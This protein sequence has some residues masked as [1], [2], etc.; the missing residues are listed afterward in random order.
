MDKTAKRIGIAVVAILIVAL[1]CV[2]IL[3]AP[4]QAETPNVSVEGNSG[5]LNTSVKAVTVNSTTYDLNDPTDANEYY[6]ML[7]KQGYEPIRDN[8]ELKNFVNNS[9]GDVDAKAAVK[10]YNG[11]ERITY[12]LGECLETK[13]SYAH[14]RNTF[15]AT[16]DGCGAA[17]DLYIARLTGSTNT[18]GGV[19]VRGDGIIED[20]IAGGAMFAEFDQIWFYGALA[21]IAYGAVVK[22]SNF[23]IS[24][25]YVYAAGS[26]SST[27]DDMEAIDWD[28]SII[29]GGLFGGMTDTTIDNCSLEVNGKVA[30]SKTSDEKSIQDGLIGFGGFAGYSY[31]STISNTSLAINK[32]I[33][34]RASGTNPSPGIYYGSPHAY[35]GG[36]VALSQGLSA[37]N[38]NITGNGAV[39]SSLGVGKKKES[40]GIARA[41]AIIGYDISNGNSALAKSEI[42]L[43]YFGSSTTAI[44]GVLTQYTG[45]TTQQSASGTGAGSTANSQS[46]L[47]GSIAAGAMANVFFASNDLNSSIKDTAK[48]AY[49]TSIK[50]SKLF[51]TSDDYGTVTIEFPN[52]TAADPNTLGGP[53]VTYSADDEAH[54]LWSY[55][56]GGS[57]TN[58]YDKQPYS[59]YSIDVT[60]NSGNDLLYS[61]TSGTRVN[62]TVRHNGDT[63]SDD[64][65]GLDATV[66]DSKQF[67]NTAFAYPELVLTAYGT[68]TSLESMSDNVINSI[69]GVYSGFN[70]S[71]R[72]EAVNVGIY[73]YRLTSNYNSGLTYDFVDTEKRYVAYKSD[74]SD[75][76]NIVR[77]YRFEITPREIT[78]TINQPD[79]VYD[80]TIKSLDID[81]K[82][83]VQGYTT[84]T[85]NVSYLNGNSEFISADEIVD[86]GTYYATITGVN[87]A[88]YKVTNLAEWEDYSFEIAKKS[89]TIQVSGYESLVYNGDTQ[90]PEVSTDA[91][92]GDNPI[93]ILYYRQNDLTNALLNEDRVDVGDYQMVVTLTDDDNYVLDNSSLTP[94]EGVLSFTDTT[95]T[96]NYSIT[97]AEL[98]FVGNENN[99]FKVV[100]FST[101]I[102][103]LSTLNSQLEQKAYFQPVDESNTKDKDIDGR[104]DIYVDFLSNEMVVTAGSYEVELSIK[105]ATN[106]KDISQPIT[107]VITPMPLTLNFADASVTSFEYGEV[108]NYAYSTEDTGAYDNNRVELAVVYYKD[109]VSAENKFDGVPTDAGSY[110]AQVEAVS[111]A[112][113]AILNS[114]TVSET[115]NNSVA[116]EITKKALT[117]TYGGE[118]QVTYD[119]TDRSPVTIASIDGVIDKDI[120]TLD[121]LKTVYTLNDVTSDT[122]RNAQTYT[123]GIAPVDP[124][125]EAFVNNYSFDTASVT[126]DKAPLTIALL[127]YETDYAAAVGGSIPYGEGVTFSVESGEI[128]G[129]DGSDAEGDGLFVVTVTGKVND[130]TVNNDQTTID[131]LGTYV[132]TMTL[133]DANS[134]AAN[135]DLTV[136]ASTGA[137]ELS[138]ENAGTIVVNGTAIQHKINVTDED[139]NSVAVASASDEAPN[140]YTIDVDYRASELTVTLQI[141]TTAGPM[142][143]LTFDVPATVTN[144]TGQGLNEGGMPYF[145]ARNANT[146]TATFTIASE[147]QGKFFFPNA[148][149]E[150]TGNPSLT[151]NFTINKLAVEVVPNDVQV[152]YGNAFAPNGYTIVGDDDGLKQGAFDADGAN[153]SIVADSYQVT[154][155]VGTIPN[156]VTI[157]GVTFS[158]EAL[159]NNYQLTSDATAD[160]TVEGRPVTIS[161]A[162]TTNSVTYGDPMP[163]EFT[164]SAVEDTTFANSDDITAAV[165][166]RLG[167]TQLNVGT[168]YVSLDGDGAIGNYIV[169]LAANTGAVTIGPKTIDI[170]V[171]NGNVDYGTTSVVPVQKGVYYTNEPAFAYDDAPEFAFV[172]TGEASLDELEPQTTVDGMLELRIVDETLAGNYTLNFTTNGSVTVLAMQLVDGMITVTLDSDVYTGEEIS[173]EI[174]GVNKLDKVSVSVTANGENATVLNAGDYTFTIS[175]DGNYYQ[176]SVSVVKTVAKAQLPDSVALVTSSATYSG[177]SFE[178]SLAISDDIQVTFAVMQDGAEAELVNA[179]SYDIVITAA[180]PNYQGSVTK[181]FAIAKATFATPVEADLTIDVV[182][183]AITI[184]RDGYT[185][186]I[187]LDNGSNWTDTTVSDLKPDTQYTVTV[188]YKADANHNESGTAMISVTTPIRSAY[189]FEIG[190][191][192]EHFD[193]VVVTI[194]VEGGVPQY[195]LDG[196]TWQNFA[197]VSGNKYTVSG[198]DELTDYTISVRIPADA[199]HE[200]SEVKTTD[201]STGIDPA[202]YNETLASFTGSSFTAAD[203]GRYATLVEQYGQLTE[204]DRETVDLSSYQAIVEAH[205]TYIRGINSD[206]SDAQ[207]VA[208]KAA[209]MAGAAA[210]AAVAAALAIVIA[211]R[212]FI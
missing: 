153:V 206:I 36:M 79:F 30:G 18:D 185:V 165:S 81:L 49:N 118:T 13:A 117:V 12:N 74:N 43:Q 199:A 138:Q 211:K 144:A 143:G 50:G 193:R 70:T 156:A 66:V 205:A 208:A 59:T 25:G 84:P 149:G 29:F 75:N 61:F 87:D 183:N 31:A 154:T 177:E 1:V 180:D 167:Y 5:T 158:D 4:R 161:V 122:V 19:V 151:I 119:G 133:N 171:A 98:K 136:T 48:L 58:V 139:G 69:W 27:V 63:V 181:T 10:P 42:G 9:G 11:Q 72:E 129:E 114:Y 103:D 187:S 20:Y 176:G 190:G 7:L 15:R 102:T 60:R 186:R 67:D 83:L 80:G 162:P 135:Y 17:F 125:D 21:N 16:L 164:I 110:V 155:G 65:C 56:L 77:N 204:A 194:T 159:A 26:A 6:E 128:F 91:S 113:Q 32:E 137:N 142:D 170:A 120:Y 96:V 24:K 55:D 147:S 195:S 28:S 173:Y 40:T 62:Y 71:S 38:I 191:V 169:T 53:R 39:S 51:A 198:L 89:I 182:Y 100:Y 93:Q 160:L 168:S 121:T 115:S 210:A 107:I 35:A 45:N 196:E 52:A 131:S 202:K 95:V 179:G 152:T 178:S 108:P 8:D 112:S 109:S 132:F 127:D 23:V 192:E 2:G 207:D 188:K 174:G 97:K 78:V 57:I 111:A 134:N 37:Y 172:Y 141:V 145:T 197:S 175:G 3:F 166:E 203:L 34:V 94:I 123:V 92:E 44:N 130:G 209:G 201:V 101:P 212:R 64:H 105:D 116:F 86:A 163:T 54:I 200:E 73:S 85:V 189:E 33:Y 14:N 47:A 22:N 82:G 90:S 126:V 46:T 41:G 68:G 150:N 184:T 157:G 88:N 148:D 140:T 99:T 76:G 106:F 146:Y 104:G 124:E